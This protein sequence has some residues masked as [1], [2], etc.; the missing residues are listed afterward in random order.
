MAYTLQ[1]IKDFLE[2]SSS[3][4]EMVFPEILLTH[5]SEWEE[6]GDK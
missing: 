2:E 1:K 4:N 5:I 6:E 3:R